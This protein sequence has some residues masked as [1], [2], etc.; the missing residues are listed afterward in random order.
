M[1]KNLVVIPVALIYLGVGA[2]SIVKEP[3][4]GSPEPKGVPA[5]V[6][7]ALASGA[8]SSG[9]VVFTGH[10]MPGHIVEGIVG[11][12]AYV[13]YP[14]PAACERML[15][16]EQAAILDLERG[17]PPDPHGEIAVG[18]HGA[19]PLVARGWVRVT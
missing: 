1:D 18:E 5:H 12:E 16:V 7:T 8:L 10:S 19:R 14:P 13:G 4:V 15:H 2:A 6:A 9:S 3:P 11:E 17:L